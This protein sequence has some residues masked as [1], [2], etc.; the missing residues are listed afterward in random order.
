MSLP[1]SSD[2]GLSAWHC[3]SSI[4]QTAVFIWL[5]SDGQPAV[6]LVFF[7]EKKFTVKFRLTTQH[8]IPHQYTMTIMNSQEMQT[9]TEIRDKGRG[10]CLLFP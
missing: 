3:R 10:F 4:A 1:S 8:H 2:D 9:G 6:N 5:G 7:E